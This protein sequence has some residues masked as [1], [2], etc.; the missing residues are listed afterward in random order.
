MSTNQASKRL[1]LTTLSTVLATP[2]GVL[3]GGLMLSRGIRAALGSNFV[4]PNLL[5]LLLALA[6]HRRTSMS[7]PL[8]KTRLINCNHG[9]HQF[10]SPQA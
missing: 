2:R 3:L 9:T 6:L 7:V 10:I 4:I 8:A 1:R 5:A